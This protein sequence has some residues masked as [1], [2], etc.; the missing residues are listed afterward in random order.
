MGRRDGPRGGVTRR[1]GGATRPPPIRG[2]RRA[3]VAV[4]CRLGVLALPLVAASMLSAQP[5]PARHGPAAPDALLREA[6]RAGVEAGSEVDRYLRALQLAGVAP[7]RAWSLRGLAPSEARAAMPAQMA[8]PWRGAGAMP[9][10]ISGPVW[11]GAEAGGAYNTGF[12]Y[13]DN[14]GP[15][16]RG[17]GGT[18]WGRAGAAWEVPHLS[19]VVRPIAFWAENR[20]FALHPNGRAGPLRF[21][22]PVDPTTIDHPQAFG[23]AAYWRVDPGESTARL[24]GQGL[25]AGVSTA[26]QAWGPADRH[27][28]L[29]GTN[30]PGFP[31]AFA[32]TSAPAALGGLGLHVRLVA[33]R[34]GQSP[35]SAMPGDSGARLAT[36]LVVLLAPPR[37]GGLEVGVTRFIHERWPDRPGLDILGAPFRG[38]L[39]GSAG[40]PTSGDPDSARVNSLASVFARLPVPRA[41]VEVYGE[42]ARNDRAHDLRDLTLEPDHASAFLLGAGRVWATPD[43]A[44]MTVLRAELV[45][46]RLTHLDRVREQ[47]RLYQHTGLLQGHTHRG[48]LLGSPAALGGS[49]HSLALDRYDARGRVTLSWDRTVRA[50]PLGEGAAAGSMHVQ[51]ALGASVLRFGR[52]FTTEA[53]AALAYDIDRNFDRDALN[54]AVGVALRRPGGR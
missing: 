20:G 15:V 6:R 39:A 41:R 19:V 28:L 17:R 3:S 18:A 9:T 49:G 34:L 50:Q 10:V 1:A 22:D 7:L 23:D 11:L 12:P 40:S 29:V 16:W 54:L 35:Y 26:M 36:G 8:H 43:L 32:G 53:S 33:G 44:R 14:E 52:R 42:F 48:R 2:P 47:P 5:A 46:A 13:G 25:A 31:H 51:H 24:E 21:G 30:A 37:L 45:S 38:L 27:N 4:L